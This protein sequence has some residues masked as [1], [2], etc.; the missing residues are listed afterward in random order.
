MQNL[1]ET[2][3]SDRLVAQLSPISALPLER[4]F[5]Y[6]NATH[7]LLASTDKS[8]QSYRVIRFTKNNETLKYELEATHDTYGEVVRR[9]DSLGRLQSAGAAYGVI[10]FFRFLRGYYIMLVTKRC[11]VGRIG[12][13]V[14]YECRDTITLSLLRDQSTFGIGKRDDETKYVELMKSLNFGNFF[15]FSYTYDLTNTLQANMVHRPPQAKPSDL[16]HAE[17]SDVKKEQ[18]SFNTRSESPNPNVR[19]ESPTTSHTENESRSAAVELPHHRFHKRSGNSKQGFRANSDTGD[20]SYQNVAA[21][22]SAPGAHSPVEEREAPPVRTQFLWNEYLLEALQ[23]SFPEKGK[24]VLYYD[25]VTEG[26]FMSESVAGPLSFGRGNAGG[27]G[28]LNATFAQSGYHMEDPLLP[29]I[30]HVI[31]GYVVHSRIQTCAGQIS[32]TLIARKNKYYAGSRYLKRGVIDSGHVANHV[33]V[34]QIV[35]DNNSLCCAETKGKFSS[36][37]QIRGSVPVH[38]YH[39]TSRAPQPPIRL[40][41]YDPTYRATRKHFNLLIQDFGAPIFIIN[42]LKRKEKKG[43]ER[44]LNEEYEKAISTLTRHHRTTVNASQATTSDRNGSSFRSRRSSIRSE[45]GKTHS[46]SDAG[47]VDAGS[48][49]VTEEERSSAERLDEA[50]GFCDAEIDLQSEDI[51]CYR[52]FDLRNNTGQA[53]NTLTSLAE[54]A[55]ERTGVFWCTPNEL[56]LQQGIVRTNCVDC[57]DRTNFAK[58]VIGLRVLGEQLAA[59]GL[60]QKSTDLAELPSVQNLF[61][62]MYLETGDALAVQYGGSATVGVGGLVDRGRGWD[63]LMELQ[64]LYNNILSDGEK[65]QAYNLFLGLYRPCPLHPPPPDEFHLPKY[66]PPRGAFASFFSSQPDPRRVIDIGDM[67]S[68]QLLHARTIPPCKSPEDCD[69]WW[70]QAWVTF[71]RRYR[72]LPPQRLL[73]PQPSPSNSMTQISA[74]Q[75]QEN[76]HVGQGSSAPPPDGTTSSL[77]Q[78]DDAPFLATEDQTSE[79]QEGALA[80]SM[81]VR[82]SV[83]S[84]GTHEVESR[85]STGFDY[86]DTDVLGDDTQDT[87]PTQLYLSLAARH[88]LVSG[89]V[90]L[91]DSDE[92]GDDDIRTLKKV[93]VYRSKGSAQS[94]QGAEYRH[95]QESHAYLTAGR[96]SPLL[97][98]DADVDETIDYPLGFRYGA[99]DGPELTFDL[100]QHRKELAN[101]PYTEERRR[102][103]GMSRER[104]RDNFSFDIS[105]RDIAPLLAVLIK[106]GP[107]DDWVDADLPRAMRLC[108]LSEGII[109]EV[110]ASGLTLKGFMFTPHSRG[111]AL[112]KGNWEAVRWF[113]GVINQ[114]NVMMKNVSERVEYKDFALDIKVEQEDASAV[115]A[116]N[117]AIIEVRRHSCLDVNILT[118]EK[119]VTDWL[120]IMLDPE[121]GL[122][123]SDRVRYVEGESLANTSVPTAQAV[124]TAV[125][126]AQF[127]NWVTANAKKLHLKL[128]FLEDE[129][130]R[131]VEARG[132]LSTLIRGCLFH[133]VST[134]SPTSLKGLVDPH[135]PLFASHNEH[136]LYRPFRLHERIILNADIP[137]NKCDLLSL[138]SVI[139]ESLANI[140][141]QLFEEEME[142]KVTRTAAMEELSHLSHLLQGVDLSLLT[143][144]ETQIAFWINVFNAL[145]V[146]S[147]FHALA[148]PAMDFNIAERCYRY[149]IGEYNLSLMDIKHGILRG[150]RRS[151]RALLPRFLHGDPRLSLTIKYTS[152]LR[153]K[154]IENK[155]LLALMDIY[156]TPQGASESETHYEPADAGSPLGAPG[157][158]FWRLSSNP[159]GQGPSGSA[160]GNPSPEEEEDGDDCE[161]ELP[162][163]D[164]P[165]TLTAAKPASLLGWILGGRQ[166][167]K[168]PPHLCMAMI[169]SQLEERL[170]LVESDFLA[171]L[172]TQADTVDPVVIR[173]FQNLVGLPEFGR[174]KEEVIRRLQLA[175]RSKSKTASPSPVASPYRRRPRQTLS[176][177]GTSG[178]PLSP[179]NARRLT[180][181]GDTSSPQSPTVVVKSPRRR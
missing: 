74:R 167:S 50:D 19:S 18:E 80:S 149:N 131:A 161:E 21:A 109:K 71:F 96:A 100:A 125:T 170:D 66:Q 37:V 20:R 2:Y 53:W 25:S 22:E 158:S 121:H 41:Y 155:V 91:I 178:P 54:S 162:T 115:A 117:D 31:H 69:L 11:R 181:L 171:P 6:E 92:E 105:K 44:L 130:Q 174:T 46:S 99:K 79:N 144:V 172:Q 61:F 85:E 23:T 111:L 14:I 24:E 35:S 42:L 118:I 60:L 40:S 108:N 135:H 142:Q 119:I 10:G 112:F 3:T 165:R 106:M 30:V 65:Q 127:I 78:L 147:W 4:H 94:G 72:P 128:Q 126:G 113:L 73:K 84:R 148:Q 164:V 28:G 160:S 76:L 63:R 70:R 33:E 56:Q 102:L 120:T 177:T 12:P 132:F 62:K 139:A 116:A 145:H 104:E 67:E 82:S 137:A 26:T 138:P 169:P 17:S 38:W 64:R 87:N 49:R 7:V 151:P 175:A 146:Q 124:T 103:K 95:Y 29:L 93:N 59:I 173:R 122:P 5:F 86:T 89:I 77:P 36:F 153:A 143:D 107:T 16:P 83:V 133:H 27:A 180:G 68:D 52:S 8:A 168:E 97:P 129:F 157:T 32:L 152:A 134:P 140:A 114:Y 141:F 9:V 1:R 101:H 123:F 166:S 110:E 58:T 98:A 88:K 150:N 75:S 34:E 48:A 15:Y 57:V 39:P 163:D 45:G 159:G 81:H 176:L 55:I 156:V 90:T 51:L 136:S 47:K 154:D 43:R 13:H 179:S